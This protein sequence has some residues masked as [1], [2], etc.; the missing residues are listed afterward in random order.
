M[1]NDQDPVV[2]EPA[3]AP[4]YDAALVP[5]GWPATMGANLRDQ[6][7]MLRARDEKLG[8]TLGAKRLY[9]AETPRGVLVRPDPNHTLLF[10]KDHPRAGEERYDWDPPRADGVQLGKLKPESE[11]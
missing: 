10:P 6:V 8:P 9:S 3:A 1:S 7:A 2:S 5:K 11:E 4:K